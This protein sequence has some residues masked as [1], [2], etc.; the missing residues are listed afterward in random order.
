M[1]RR[2]RKV[3]GGLEIN[4]Y[5]DANSLTPPGDDALSFTAYVA[6]RPGDPIYDLC[7]PPEHFGFTKASPSDA[8]TTKILVCEHCAKAEFI[9]NFFQ[10]FVASPD[11][12][13]WL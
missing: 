4:Y 11:G 8:C 3:K 13:A 5:R 2:V 7:L 9:S 10:S 1:H 12:D 6:P